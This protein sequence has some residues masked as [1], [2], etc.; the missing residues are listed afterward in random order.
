M[1]TLRRALAWED[2][3]R[4]GGAL[5][6]VIAIILAGLISVTALGFGIAFFLGAG[7]EVTS[8]ADNPAGPW[9]LLAMGVGVAV[10]VVVAL[11]RQ[12][13]RWEAVHGPAE[14]TM[15]LRW[16]PA[17]CAGA[18]GEVALV[19]ALALLFDEG[20]YAAIA[21]AMVGVAG[22][23]VA[24]FGARRWMRSRSTGQEADPAGVD[25]GGS[26]AGT[27]APSRDIPG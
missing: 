4:P 8:E 19:G 1:E 3:Q 27:G 18:I 16:R 26:G 10:G 14:P 17:L 22:F 6:L 12:A 7:D 2:Q 5:Q 11:R 13:R 25:A 15:P 20:L 24:V 21:F 23:V 9:I